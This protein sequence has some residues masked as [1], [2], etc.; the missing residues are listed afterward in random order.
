MTIK[1]VSEW[2]GEI[3]THSIL[4]CDE[5]KEDFFRDTD[6]IA[7]WGAGFSRKQMNRQIDARGKG[8]SIDGPEDGKKLIGALD[9]AYACYGKWSGDEQAASK[10]GMGSQFREYVCA[11]KRAGH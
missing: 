5:A 1:K 3:G 6:Q 9:V 4:I 8:G 10:F 2:L 11:L 7:P